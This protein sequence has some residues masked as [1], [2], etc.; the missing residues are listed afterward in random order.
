MESKQA[1]QMVAWLD[2]ERRK[3]KALIIKLEERAAAQAAH[4]EDQARR[5][6]ALE[7]ELI[8]V[9][10]TSLS[11]STFDEAISRLRSE[12][13]AG[14]EQMQARNTEQDQRRFQDLIREGTQKALDDM[15]DE[16]QTRLER[17]IQPRRAEEERLSRVA[18][19]LQNYAD[20][21]S[22]NLEEFQ[23]TLTFLEEQR[24][25]DGRRLSDVSGAQAE[26]GKKVEGASAKLELLEEIT[27]RNERGIAELAST[28]TEFRQQRQQAIEQDTIA[29]RQREKLLADMIRKVEDSMKKFEKNFDHW[30]E[31]ARTM[32]KQ[33]DDFDHL[34]ERME[35]R[36]NEVSEIQR[37]S[38]ERFR[39]EWEEFQQEDQKHFRQFTLT[40]DESWR[41]SNKIV[42]VLSER[43]GTLAEISDQLSA[44]LGGMLGTQRDALDGL[45]A[46]VQTMREQVEPA[47]PAKSRAK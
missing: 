47:R 13:A 30:T 12:V 11:S 19:E 8:S 5:V 29:E 28:V 36:L 33:V 10:T 35:R 22:K 1:A 46:I 9:R 20:S 24:R 44:Q 7:N 41:E 18:V 43:V 14:L 32:K 4:I 31:T 26:A 6:Q 37:L 25:Q 23:R 16:I 34:A 42:T 2:E 3:D 15:R 45:A 27:R 17:E 38:E 40:N 39:R 21:L